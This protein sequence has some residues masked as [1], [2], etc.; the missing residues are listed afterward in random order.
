MKKTKLSLQ[1]VFVSLKTLN[2]K[3]KLLLNVQYTH[4]I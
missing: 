2:F 3:S 1:L 4:P